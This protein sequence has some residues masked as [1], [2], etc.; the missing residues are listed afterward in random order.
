MQLS[1]TVILIGI[2]SIISIMAFNN[3]SQMNKLI[4]HPYTVKREGQW[5]RFIS[6]AFIHGDWM[7]LLFNMFTLYWFGQLIELGVLKRQFGQE[8]G[9]ILYIALFL[10]GVI[11][12]H[13]PT[14]QKHKDSPHYR[15][16]GASGGVSAVL[17]ACIMFFPLEDICIYGILC[18]PGFIIGPLYLVYT[19]YRGKQ[20]NDNIN[21]D[22][23]LYGALF[24]I[25]FSLII[26]PTVLGDFFRQVMAWRI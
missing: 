18:I 15:S 25:L 26:Q 9:A 7:H 23:H 17:F 8:T 24:G 11:V 13:L 14:Y 22:A 1:I 20:G 12:A 6:S 4:F 3:N 19:Y 16:L 5:Y 2:I 21:H 10:V